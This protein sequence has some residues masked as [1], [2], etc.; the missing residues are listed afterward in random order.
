M[1]K[2]DRILDFVTVTIANGI[3]AV[4]IACIFI[5]INVEI[6]CRYA[7]NTSTLIADEYCGYLFAIAVYAGLS[8]GM[9]QDKLIKIDLPG[10]WAEFV[11]QPF[12]R[13]IVHLAALV[14]NSILLYAIWQTFSAS[15][16]FTS[17][18]IQPSRTLLAYPQG[19]VVGGIALLF[20]V[21]LC[22]FVRSVVRCLSPAG[23][24]GVAE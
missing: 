13:M 5:I 7:F 11:K 23:E 24:K 12:V 10:A 21:S 6:V 18:S 8:A 2:Y 4:L 16:L 1:S 20:L 22:Q 17:R 9:Y 3:A 14:L 19:A 15:L